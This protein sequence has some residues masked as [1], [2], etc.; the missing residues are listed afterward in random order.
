MPYYGNLAV[1]PATSPQQPPQRPQP[2]RE[3]EQRVDT[4]KVI[5]RRNLPLGEK[6]LYLFTIVV[7]VLVAGLII[8]RYAEIYQLNRE[9]QSTQQEFER[10]SEQIK[11]LQRD[12]ERLSDPKRILQKATEYGMVPIDGHG[13]IV[14]SKDGYAGK[15]AE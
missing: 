14:T 9:I 3:E 6:L 10:T 7:V 11:E 15:A 8:F 4:R 12:V 5:R 2:Q 1:R 13:I